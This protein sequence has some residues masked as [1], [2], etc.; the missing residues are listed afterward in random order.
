MWTPPALDTAEYMVR[1]HTQP[2]HTTHSLFLCTNRLYH[3]WFDAP[4]CKSAE[5]DR[6]F[7][8]GDSSSAAEFFVTIGVFS[9]LYSMAALYVYIFLLEKYRE[10]NRGAQAVSVLIFYTLF[11]LF[12][13]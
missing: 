9:F 12:A 6:L 13:C 1:K 10:G 5:P 3:V 2:Y 7:L 4:T 11:I 8:E